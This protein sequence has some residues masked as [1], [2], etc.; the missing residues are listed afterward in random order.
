M[1]NE[2]IK[3]FNDLYCHKNGRPAVDP[4]VLFKMLF[5]VYIYSV[6]GCEKVSERCLL[7]EA[8]QNME[9]IAM[10]LSL[11]YSDFIIIFNVRLIHNL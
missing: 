8:M 5:I 2:E 11:L 10:R 6:R 9:K 3:L 4:V 7:T 1:Q